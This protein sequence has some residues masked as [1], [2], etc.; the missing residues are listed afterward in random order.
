LKKCLYCDFYS[1]TETEQVEAFLDALTHEITLSADRYK[2]T[3]TSTIFF[4]GGTP[5]LL[6]PS[7]LERILIALGTVFRIVPDAEV[8]LEAN[9]GTV[10]R[11]KLRVFRALGINRLSLGIQSFLDAELHTL[12]RVH[13]RAEAL[14]SV[15]FARD[16]AFDDISLDLIYAIPGQ[17]VASWEE[18]LRA[19]VELTPQHISAY[20]LTVEDGT[21]LSRLVQA[22]EVR[23]TPSS[24]QAEMFEQAHAFLNAHGYEHYEVSN[25]ALPGLRCRHNCNYWSHENYLGFGPSAHSF[26]REPDR[27]RGRRVWNVA[28]LTTYL[29]CLEDGQMPVGSEEHVGPDELI[30]ERIFLGLRSSGL[31]LARLRQDLGYDIV[32]HRGDVIRNLLDERLALL[33]GDVLLL[34]L[35]G[36]LL[37]DEICERLFP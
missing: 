21:P 37:C 3:E 12:G 19:A 18:T 2:D 35:R 22:G 11:E 5:S 9:P 17:T 1:V 16:A 31:N 28:D 10:T 20:S 33:E 27:T 8:T 13:D 4:G 32:A 36:F 15:G 24:L 7:Q 23:M 34:T 25:Y 30:H 29:A 14:R 26:W 6:E